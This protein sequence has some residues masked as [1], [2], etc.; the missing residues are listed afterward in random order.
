MNDGAVSAS[1]EIERLCIFG[2]SQRAKNL[3]VF[4]FFGT[5]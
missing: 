4:P 5:N 1:Q 2:Y 3:S